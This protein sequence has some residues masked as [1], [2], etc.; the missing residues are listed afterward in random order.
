MHNSLSRLEDEG[1]RGGA[2]GFAAA[3]DERD[4]SNAVTRPPETVQLP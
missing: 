1:D 4:Q 3:I 2:G